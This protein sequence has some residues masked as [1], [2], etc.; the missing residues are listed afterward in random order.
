M[1]KVHILIEQI[2]LGIQKLSFQIK[3]IKFLQYLTKMQ[4]RFQVLPSMN[5]QTGNK[6]DEGANNSLNTVKEIFLLR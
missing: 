2:Y 4:A 3:D 1:H 5:A 6:K